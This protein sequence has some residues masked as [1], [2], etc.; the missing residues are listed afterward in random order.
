MTDTMELHR[1]TK[2]CRPMQARGGKKWA[3]P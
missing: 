2:W 1:C 3:L